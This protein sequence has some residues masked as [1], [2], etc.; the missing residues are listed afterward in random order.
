MNIEERKK[1]ANLNSAWLAGEKIEGLRFRHNST[2]RVTLADG[3]TMT[4]WIVAASV[5][6]PKPIYTVEAQDG[7]GDMECFESAISEYEK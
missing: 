6:G 2:V 5:D 1:Q 3:T 7:S 4:G